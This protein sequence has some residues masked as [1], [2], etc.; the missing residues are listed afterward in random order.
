MNTNNIEGYLLLAK[1]D[2]GNVRQIIIDQDKIKYSLLDFCKIEDNQV[3]VVEEPSPI[4]FD[5]NKVEE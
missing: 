5:I 2:D 1:F 3:L 4:D